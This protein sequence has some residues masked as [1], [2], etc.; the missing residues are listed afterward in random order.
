MRILITAGPTREYL[1]DVR[2]LSNASSGRM[3]YAIAE[4][5]LAAGHEAVLVSGPVSLTPSLGCEVHQVETTE[6]LHTVCNRLFVGCQGVIATAAVCDYR[7]RERFQGKL[8]K[9]GVS[10]ELELVETADVLADLGQQKGPRWIV[11]FAL[12]SDEFAHINALRKLKQKNCDAI[13]LNRPTAIGSTDN[14]IEIINQSGQS[15]V[16][17]SG[18]KSDV[19]RELWQWIENHLVEPLA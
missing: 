17:Y 3:G 2:Y 14:Q 11:G 6:E 1:D 18:T 13:V 15:V 12:E 5:V 8:A 10:L 9:T 4:A 7:P 19:A 16:K